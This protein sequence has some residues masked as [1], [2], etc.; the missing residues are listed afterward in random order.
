MIHKDHLK[1]N[2]GCP[3]NDVLTALVHWRAQSALA[4]PDITMLAKLEFFRS[5]NCFVVLSFSVTLA[6]T[7][8]IC[9]GMIASVS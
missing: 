9:H 5:V 2:S 7:T 6:P 1:A 8:S 4:V 3:A